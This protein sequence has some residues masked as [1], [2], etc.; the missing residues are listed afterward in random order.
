MII[1]YLTVKV[2]GERSLLSS[3]LIIRGSLRFSLIA[4][5]GIN[6]RYRLIKSL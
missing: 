1:C 6:K 3:N 2:I 5:I 4:I